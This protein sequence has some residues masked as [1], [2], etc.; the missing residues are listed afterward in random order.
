MV[1]CSLPPSP[2]HSSPLC[3]LVPARHSLPPSSRKTQD[4]NSMQASCSACLCLVT[5]RLVPRVVC[6]IP[7]PQERAFIRFFELQI[8]QALLLQDLTSNLS[9]SCL[10]QLQVL[11]IDDPW[12]KPSRKA[13]GM[14]CS[15][16][17][18]V[19]KGC[20]PADGGSYL[21]PL[22]ASTCADL[23]LSSS[24][25]RTLGHNLY[26]S[27]PG[28]HISNVTLPCSPLSIPPRAPEP[29]EA[30]ARTHF[31]HERTLFAP[32]TAAGPRSTHRDGDEQQ[33][34]LPCAWIRHLADVSARRDAWV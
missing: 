20:G 7:C 1:G 25:C 6:G 3:P 11:R 23:S 27:G 8:S 2:F 4:I 19:L 33:L 32:H 10:H 15:E 9:L 26:S 29:E 14:T 16:A 31:D 28:K 5:L 34:R 13:N 12:S 18:S 21:S 22:P 30:A 17:C 24:T